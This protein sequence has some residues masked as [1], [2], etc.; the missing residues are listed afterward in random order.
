MPR[1]LLVCALFA[2]LSCS[3]ATPS[4]DAT[5]TY[6]KAPCFSCDAATG[7]CSSVPPTL[8]M[9]HGEVAYWTICCSNQTGPCNVGFSLGISGGG[10]STLKYSLS[11]GTSVA[12]PPHG[13]WMC[14]IG[15]SGSPSGPYL[16]DQ[17]TIPSGTCYSGEIECN[18][19][20]EHCGVYVKFAALGQIS[21]TT[22]TLK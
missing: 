9:N 2:V 14:Q 20:F 18:N 10:S 1:A 7:D 15:W 19:Y 5:S 4:S 11:N 22:C 12:C 8:S 16:A 13:Y 6:D 17:Y 21:P 3:L